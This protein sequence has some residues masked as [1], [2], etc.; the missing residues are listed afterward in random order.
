[1]ELGAFPCLKTLKQNVSMY[2]QSTGKGN[3][4]KDNQSPY[5]GRQGQGSLPRGRAQPIGLGL[6]PG[7]APGP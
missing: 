1:M 4:G 5:V 7:Q 2:G 6:W 3:Q